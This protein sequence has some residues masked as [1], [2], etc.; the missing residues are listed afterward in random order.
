MIR[1]LAN[2]RILIVDDEPKNIQLLGTILK[3]EGYQLNVVNSGIKAL[4]MVK[5][6]PPELI[7]LDVMMPEMN[8]YEV[9]K[10]LKQSEVS[11]NIPIIFVTG[12]QSIADEEKGFAVG[13]VDYITKP[14]SSPIIKARVK[15]HLKLK[16]KMDLL[17]KMVSLD[18]LTEI[19]NRRSLD[20]TIEKEWNRSLRENSELSLI[21]I[22]VDQFKLYNDFY[23]HNAGDDCLKSVANA[24]KNSLQR[25]S[26]FVARY[27][28]EEFCVLLPESSLDDA[29]C[30][31]E[32][33][34]QS[35]EELEITHASSVV[36]DC[37]TISLGIASCAVNS[38]LTSV[39][40]QKLAD[41]QLYSSKKQGRNRCMGI[42]Y[43]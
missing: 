24:L 38:F 30:V 31:A 1:D 17:E 18:G 21:M 16:Q 43:S 20:E 42:V 3:Q 6:L 12:R 32:K 11:K 10:L 36:S 23:G 22:D 40:L 37:V 7:L 34:R 28:G 8:G 26:D 35:V 5:K 9:C 15:T 4:E 33:L 41:E 19:P 25:S 29:M 13:G 39:T 14:F 2:T 27:G